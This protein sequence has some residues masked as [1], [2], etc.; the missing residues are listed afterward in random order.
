M[1]DQDW[2]VLIKGLVINY[3]I[4]LGHYYQGQ[5]FI[6]RLH[7][8]LKPEKAKNEKIFYTIQ[9]MK[10]GKNKIIAVKVRILNIIKVLQQLQ[11]QNI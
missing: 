6:S 10:I 4:L 9:G 8:L 5:G 7:Q 3:L 2:A 1:T 11:K